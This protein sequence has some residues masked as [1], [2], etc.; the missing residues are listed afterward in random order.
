M[1][2]SAEFGVTTVALLRDGAQVASGSMVATWS[3][4]ASPSAT[5]SAR[6]TVAGAW[7]GSFEWEGCCR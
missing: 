2:Y 4:P 3:G 1:T 5:W 7:S 6:L